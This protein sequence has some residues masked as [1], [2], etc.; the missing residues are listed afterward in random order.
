VTRRTR[1][2]ASPALPATPARERFVAVVDRALEKAAAQKLEP[3][4]VYLTQEDAA[5]I[6]LRIHFDPPRVR[7]IEIRPVRGNGPSRLYTKF[8][9]AIGLGGIRPK[10]DRQ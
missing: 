1:A 10:E 2:P 3:R 8:G 6:G 4:A 9:L 5:A 7:G